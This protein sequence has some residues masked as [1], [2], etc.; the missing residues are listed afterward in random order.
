MFEHVPELDAT[1]GGITQIIN[2]QREL[3]I[4]PDENGAPG[5]PTIMGFRQVASGWGASI[6]ALIKI[7]RQRV[8]DGSQAASQ[9]EA[10]VRNMTAIGEIT[11]EMLGG[12]PEAAA[13]LIRRTGGLGPITPEQ[14]DGALKVLQEWRDDAEQ[15]IKAPL[16][17]LSELKKQLA[18]LKKVLKWSAHASAGIGAGVVLARLI[19]AVRKRK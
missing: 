2:G 17:W 1:G 8:A 7:W 10:A 14:A 19:E 12:S 5:G 6:D 9:R 13:E 11:Q 3:L 16:D 4:A 18:D 15:A